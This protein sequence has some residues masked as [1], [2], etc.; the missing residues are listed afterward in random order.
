MIKVKPQS[1]ISKIADVLMIPVMYFLQGNVREIP[2]RTHLWNY[3][4]LQASET[5]ELNPAY[6]VTLDKD[7]SAIRQFIRLIP[8]FHMPLL[9]GWKNFVVLQPLDPVHTY[10]NV[11]WM[12]GNLVQASRIPIRDKVRLLTPP[13]PVQFFAIAEDGTQLPLHIVGQG[14]IGRAGEFAKIPL[15]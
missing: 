15:L 11:G 6:S 7:P 2:Q 10:W 1:S 13:S 9:G 5:G 12:L 4:T 8:I 14:S 3:Q